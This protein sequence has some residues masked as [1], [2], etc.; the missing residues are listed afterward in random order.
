MKRITRVI[1]SVGGRLMDGHDVRHRHAPEI[2]VA[3]G[4]LA[5]QKRQLRPLGGG[6]IGQ[7]R[8]LPPG[9]NENFIRV[10]GEPGDAGEEGVVLGS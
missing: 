5:N 3:D 8:H 4:D 1:V 7:R 9:Q 6:E 2:I 10:P